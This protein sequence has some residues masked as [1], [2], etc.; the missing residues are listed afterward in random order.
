MDDSRDRRHTT[1]IA[2]AHSAAI[3]PYRNQE[4]GFE[5]RHPVGWEPVETLVYDPAGADPIEC[6][7]VFHEQGEFQSLALVISLASAKF[8]VGNILSELGA[9]YRA[10]AVAIAIDND[11]VEGKKRPSVLLRSDARACSFH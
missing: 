2:T 7:V 8:H 3:I 10:D 4:Y 11:L 9:S 5:V 6:Y 1:A